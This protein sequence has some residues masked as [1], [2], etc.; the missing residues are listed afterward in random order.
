MSYKYFQD[1]P[2]I[3]YEGRKVRDIT[4]RASF[5]RAVS[6]NPYVY[7]S[8]TIKDGQR[9]E[10]VALE[11]YGSVDYIWLV[12]MANNIIDPYYEWPMDA[13][14]FNDYLVDKYTAES[15]KIGEDVIDWT[16]NE[17]IDDNILY[18]IKKV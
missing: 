1:F 8:Y 12:Y 18:Y 15:G 10:D 7:Y 13:S 6:N 16:K 9:A 4:R 17:S 5:V 11:Y 3:R 2:V 14:T